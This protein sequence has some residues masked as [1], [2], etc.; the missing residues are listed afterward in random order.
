MSTVTVVGEGDPSSNLASQGVFQSPSGVVAPLNV[1]ALHWGMCHWTGHPVEVQ[2]HQPLPQVRVQWGIIAGDLG[3]L[4]SNL[5]EASQQV[6][7]QL[8]CQIMI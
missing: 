4:G 3:R 5:L 7:L 1:A 6:G 2:G 8:Y